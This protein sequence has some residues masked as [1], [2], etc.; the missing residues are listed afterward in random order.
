M[1]KHPCFVIRLLRMNKIRKVALPNEI[2]FERVKELVADG[3]SVTFR[4]KGNSMNP[5]LLDCRD[6]AVV[7][8]FEK[9]DIVP[10][11]VILAEDMNGRIIL[12]RVIGVNG[13]AIKMMGDGNCR[14]T[15]RTDFSRVAG[16]VKEV[17]RNGRQISCEG[18]GWRF[19]SVC[20]N[21]LRPFRR[22][23]LAFWKRILRKI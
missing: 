23:M 16:I 2:L 11:I 4:V 8:P 6:E 15:E 10:G 3:H 17:I 12:H 14:G 1:L 18:W 9:K 19:T 21:K 22:W 7:S 5:F 20:W 13:D